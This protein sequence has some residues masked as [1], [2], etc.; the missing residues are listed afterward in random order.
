MH[1]FPLSELFYSLISQNNGE[2]TILYGPLV[3]ETAW[4]MQIMS[5]QV[6]VHGLSTYVENRYLLKLLSQLRDSCRYS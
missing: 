4:L 6:K 1:V 5:V 2:L 3:M